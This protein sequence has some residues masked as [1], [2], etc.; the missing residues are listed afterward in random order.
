[1]LWIVLPMI[2]TSCIFQKKITRECDY[3]E[4]SQKTIDLDEL[5]RIKMGCGFLY[6]QLDGDYTELI[7]YSKDS[8]LASGQGFMIL[9]VFDSSEL[10]VA[11]LNENQQISKLL[12]YSTRDK[13]IGK[14]LKLSNSLLPKYFKRECMISDGIN[15]VFYKG[16]PNEILYYYNS[17]G[18]DCEVPD[19][20]NHMEDSYELIKE[21]L[22]LGY[23]D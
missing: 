20:N 7:Y 3:F 21:L 13:R 10:Y 8:G 9:A 5:S 6:D 15:S 18:Y 11:N 23:I 2:M 12:R 14:L 17:Y 22:K 16:S 4:I 1:M 19:I